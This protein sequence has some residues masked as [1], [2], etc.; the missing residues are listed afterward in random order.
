MCS[1][2][3]DQKD[4][5]VVLKRE[6]WEI[7]QYN[8]MAKDNVNKFDFERVSMSR[9]YRGSSRKIKKKDS[10]KHSKKEKRK[11]EEG[12][13]NGYVDQVSVM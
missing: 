2:L 12:G 9:D 8:K 13:A 1:L 7:G 10:K 4:C 3:Y 5:K 11:R 6:G